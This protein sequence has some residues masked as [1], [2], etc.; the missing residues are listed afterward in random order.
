MLISTTFVYN[1][2]S[3]PMAFVA[4]SWFIDA[5]HGVSISLFLMF[6]SHFCTYLHFTLISH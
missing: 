4:D 2:F 5:P 6:S 3:K 1:Y